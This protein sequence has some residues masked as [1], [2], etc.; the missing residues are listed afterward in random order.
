[1]K[2]LISILSLVSICAFGNG[3]RQKQYYDLEARNRLFQAYLTGTTME[4][5]ACL[6]KEVKTIH[7]DKVISAEG[8]AGQVFIAYTRLYW[9]EKRYGKPDDAS[10]V[11]VQARHWNVKRFE[12]EG[13]SHEEAFSRATASD[14][15]SLAD[16]IDR[17]DRSANNGQPPKFST[18]IEQKPH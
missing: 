3:C 12:L 13:L 2:R 9:L 1:M 15:T 6:L 5:R 16:K 18:T 10:K 8:K 4:A 11:L 14:P 17:L 7:A